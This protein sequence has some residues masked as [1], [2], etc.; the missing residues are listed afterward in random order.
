MGFERTENTHSP[1]LPSAATPTLSLEVIQQR[2]D[3]LHV[4]NTKEKKGRITAQVGHA[5]S[6]LLH[7]SRL[8]RASEMQASLCYC[9][10]PRQSRQKAR[11]NTDE[12]KR[13]A[14]RSH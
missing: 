8:L 7:A 4:Q 5:G 9:L 2:Q 1:T 13:A 14:P 10:G 11:C 12:S 3:L 6:D